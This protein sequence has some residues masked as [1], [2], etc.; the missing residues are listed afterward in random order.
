MDFDGTQD[1]SVSPL[2]STIP[3][4]LGAM[5]SSKRLI[6]RG[7]LP[8]EF[9]SLIRAT[10]TDEDE[11]KVIDSLYGNNAQEFVDVVHDVRHRI[12]SPP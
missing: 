5:A 8:H 6:G 4:S 7:F 9:M 10:L 11:I 2:K 3:D 12:F 1:N